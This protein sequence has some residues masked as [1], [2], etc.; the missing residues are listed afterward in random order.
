V[1][2]TIEERTS[3]RLDPISLEVLRNRLDAIAEDAASTILRTSVSPIITESHDFGVTLLD[4]DGKL[5]AGGGRVSYHWVAATRAIRAT[6]ERFGDAIEAGDVF[7]ANDPYNGGGLHPN[8][9]FVERPIY[10]GDRR[11]AWVALSAH[12]M[13]VGGMVIGSWAP[14]AT[15]CYQEAL[16]IPPVHLFRAGVESTDV[17]DIVRTN[18]RLPSFIEMDLRALVAGSHVAEE[19]LAEVA[20]FCGLAFFLDGI[21]ALQ[22]LSERELRRRI[23]AIADGAYRVVAWNEWD[24][25][26]YRI[27]CTLTVE[28]DE[29]VFDFEGT[30]AQVP[31]YINSQPFIVKS[32][33]MMQ[34]ARLVAPDLPYSE[35]LLAPIDLRC[36]ERTIV[37]AGVPAPMGNGQVNVPMAAAEA[38]MQ[39]VR[40]ALSA[41]DPAVPASRFVHGPSA[42]QA[43][44]VT[45]WSGADADGSATTWA[46]VD[47]TGTG[48]AAAV[49]RDG[50]DLTNMLVG[51]ESPAAIADVEVLESW[52][53]MLITERR[54]RHG[55]NGAGAYRSGSGSQVRFT[56][57]GT[58][59]L[60]GQMLGLRE[61]LP[62]EG[63]AGGFPG[64][65][66]QFLLH[67]ADGTIE[68]IPN[69]AAGVV[70]E[71]GES[72]EFRC[73]SAGGFGDPVAREPEAVAADV[74]A[75]RI[76]EEDATAVYGVVLD[77]DG[78]PDPS[79]TSVRRAAILA[80][81]LAGAS[82]PV[83]ALT[84]A[85][86]V[87][88]ASGSELPLFPGVV[89]RGRVAFAAESGAP[90]AVAPDHWTDGCP[91]LEWA[92]AGEGPPV[93]V[94]AY[95]DPRSGATLHVEA[96]PAGE[97]RS[98][99]VAPRRWTEAGA[100][101]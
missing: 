58:N 4:A 57:H 56:P 37:N 28:G 35:G 65:T 97:P 42:G 26:F 21:D 12:M 8:D 64:A 71:A 31:H 38:M 52:Y 27:P 76:T 55:V 86:V 10:V 93:L 30:T 101:G 73:A 7:F 33:F 14:A 29:M 59:R 84:D 43:W 67:R 100:S 20:T 3:D 91:L 87:G 85:D 98:F 83:R 17:W 96:L 48:G 1:T 89:Q 92:P 45:S 94:R 82:A 95:L 46:I 54:V 81:R 34:F 78:R 44:S 18:V 40:L 90:L 36:P 32:A 69:K 19:K 47:G 68:R 61:W 25:D 15:E 53:P 13:D 11:I 23:R 75:G 41:T 24:D 60:V 80:D 50:L 6:I 49:D 51:A 77:R 2:S 79:A 74:A 66:G 62:V 70:V 9:V 99:T 88:I 22:L 72:F 5:V 16:R 39:C 63:A